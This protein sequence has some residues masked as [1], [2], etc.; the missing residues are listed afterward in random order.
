MHQAA[1]RQLCSPALEATPR[2]HPAHTR[3]AACP[4]SRSSASPCRAADPPRTAHPLCPCVTNAG[5]HPSGRPMP[6]P[7]SSTSLR[8]VRLGPPPLRRLN[9]EPANIHGSGSSLNHAPRPSPSA[10][11]QPCTVVP[12]LPCSTSPAPF[13]LHLSISCLLAPPSRP[14]PGNGCQLHDVMPQALLPVVLHLSENSVPLMSQ[15]AWRRRG[16]WGDCL[17]SGAAARWR[18]SEGTS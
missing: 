1:E 12:L 15:S 2:S 18:R 14:T 16:C 11:C 17:G 10:Q 5:N 13:S 8:C 4:P 9:P 7:W 6:R 3:C